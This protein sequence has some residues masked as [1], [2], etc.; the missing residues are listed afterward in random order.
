MITTIVHP[1]LGYG[2]VVSGASE[3]ED[4]IIGRG[5]SRSPVKD[6]TKAPYRWICQ[7]IATYLDSALNGGAPT[8]KI[9]TGLLIGPRHVL[10][11]A[12]CVWYEENGR[13][14]TPKQ[15]EV[16]PG[17][18]RGHLPFSSYRTSVVKFPK[19]YTPGS[20]SCFDYA[21]LTLE[22]SIGGKRFPSIGNKPLSYWGSRE[23]GND[24]RVEYVDP[25]RLRKKTVH[26]VG[27]AGDKCGFL[28]IV[29]FNPGDKCYDG[30]P[31]P[32][33]ATLKQC[34]KNGLGGSAQYGDKGKVLEM[35]AG[36]PGQFLLYDADTCGSQSGGPVWM[37]SGGDR[38]L[39][40][41][42]TGFFNLAKGTCQDATYGSAA[43]ANRA[44]RLDQ[45]VL[46][47]I[48]SWM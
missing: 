9:G 45:A 5:D 34:L 46:R 41:I 48:R 25:A 2:T 8:K 26:V 24:T 43:D 20:G 6:T 7:I 42:H 12:H 33:D 10:T 18:S 47:N 32:G 19:E 27:Y 15:V 37:L 36:G 23:T 17:R 39:V 16:Y 13:A 28:P 21:L 11:A 1:Q 29:P 44:I 3:L 22:E 14:Y 35:R 40:G 38:Y 30:R 4:E 31:T